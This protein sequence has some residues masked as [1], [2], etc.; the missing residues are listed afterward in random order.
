MAIYITYDYALGEATILAREDNTP[1][2][3]VLWPLGSI[4][5]EDRKPLTRDHRTK[6]TEV[7]PSGER[8][9]V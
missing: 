8:R 6:V 9:D 4:T 3:A 7:M 2:Y 5:V 1:Y